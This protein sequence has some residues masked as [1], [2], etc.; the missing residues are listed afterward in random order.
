[1]MQYSSKRFQLRIPAQIEKTTRFTP[2]LR[3]A[4]AFVYHPWLK[5]WII[6][7]PMQK[8]KVRVAWH[9]PHCFWDIP[10]SP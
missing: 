7:D 1:M 3:T 10:A 4:S 2:T 6:T 9:G 8:A 5:E